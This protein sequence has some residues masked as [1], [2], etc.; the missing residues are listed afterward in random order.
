MVSGAILRSYDQTAD[1]IKL[2]NSAREKR[3]L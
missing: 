3:Q 2:I 1:K